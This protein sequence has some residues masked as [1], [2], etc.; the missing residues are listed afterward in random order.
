MN[1]TNVTIGF[2]NL[3]PLLLVTLTRVIQNLCP[4]FEQNLTHP[5][6]QRQNKA[7]KFNS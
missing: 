3:Q 5:Y 2:N 4:I 7:N 1:S 6:A